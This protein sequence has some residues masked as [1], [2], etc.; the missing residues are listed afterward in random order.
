MVTSIQQFYEI[1]LTY[2]FYIYIFYDSMRLIVKYE[3]FNWSNYN[4]ITLY[5]CWCIKYICVSINNTKQSIMNFYYINTINKYKLQQCTNY[6]L[7]Q[8]INVI[9]KERES[10]RWWHLCAYKVLIS[11]WRYHD[12]TFRVVI[13]LLYITTCYMLHIIFLTAYGNKKWSKRKVYTHL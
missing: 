6:C 9:L 13:K 8:N 3:L 10:L 11:C 7:L 12:Q 2:I 4:F 5:K 1:T